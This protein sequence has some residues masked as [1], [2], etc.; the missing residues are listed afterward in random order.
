LN[1]SAILLK[2][3]EKLNR[4]SSSSY[5]QIF[6]ST[7]IIGGASVINIILRIIRTK[8]L[9]ILLGPTGIGLM[10]IYSS[11]MTTTVAIAGCGLSSSGVRQIAEAQATNDQVMIANT[12]KALLW[13]TG[14]L[15]ILGA[16]FLLLL[17]NE[18]SYRTFGNYHHQIAIAILSVGVF[19][20]V[21]GGSQGAV[22]QGLRRIGDLARINII[23]ASSGTILA[24]IFI[25]FLGE[26]GVACF[27]AATA[28][29]TLVISWYYLGKIS[30]GA[31][32][33]KTVEIKRQIVILLRLGFV[34][35]STGFLAEGTQ[36]VIRVLI[37]RELGL[38]AT[39]YF[40]AAWTISMLYVGFILNAMGT[41]F[42][43]RLTALSNDHIAM[44]RLINE[45]A[46]VALLLAGPVILGMLTFTP[47]VTSLLYAPAFAS[48]NVILRWQ[49]IGTLFKVV[50]WP[51]SFAIIAKGFGLVYFFSE[52]IWYLFYITGIFLSIKYIGLVSTGV[53]F[54]VAYFIYIFVVY[55]ITVRVINFVPWFKT[56]IITI[57]I[58]TCLSLIFFLSYISLNISY[59]VGG[60]I[61][62]MSSIYS[63]TEL[64]RIAGQHSI[65]RMVKGIK[66]R[67]LR[68]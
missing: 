12:R 36:Y 11:I 22:L 7:A 62:V 53:S 54:A 50:S 26:G 41:D 37:N 15:A 20:S 65:V 66:N 5:S 33:I 52:L 49:V 19:M 13:S 61:T 3:E 32:E 45:Q 47:L 17:G 60:V 23:G 28:I 38:E 21:L 31:A 4:E 39:G 56:V 51:M 58:G 57:V 44:N 48:S 16:L 46:E 67:L 40:H 18:I 6:K 68:S 34:F 27:L 29:T 8:V 24:I 35:M 42:Y 10:G 63:V 64:N 9:A 2:Q 59:I 43:P 14:I 55:F 30:R 25:Y 1:G